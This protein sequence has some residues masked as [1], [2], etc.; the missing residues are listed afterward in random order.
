MIYGL[1]THAIAREQLEGHHLDQIAD[2]GFDTIEIFANRHQV[3]FDNPEALRSIARAVDRNGLY[4]NSVHAPFYRS[5]EEIQQGIHLDIGSANESERRSSVDE[6]AASF[7]LGTLFH[8]DYYILHAP[9]RPDPDALMKSLDELLTLSKELPFKLCM[10]NIPGK[11]TSL[12]H[13]HELMDR[14]LLPIGICFDTGHSNLSGDVAAD[15]REYGASF[16]TAHIH[17]NDGTNDNHMM[18]FEGQI[19]WDSVMDAF[20]EVDYKWGFMLEV[21]RN[22]DTPLD[23][24]LGRCT[25]VLERFRV[26]ETGSR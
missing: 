6:I 13:I 15:I 3:D 10:E 25:A 12:A 26:L 23:A 4:V 22:P 8:V 5:I 11:T 9:D 2:G 7:V 1:S 17:D 18:P 20:R 16:Y 14:H 24:F 21:R 19:D